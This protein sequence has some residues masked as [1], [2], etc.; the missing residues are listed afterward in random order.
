MDAGYADQAHMS[1]Q[2]RRFS[3]MTI[4]RFLA[5]MRERRDWLQSGDVAFV[6]YEAA[7]G[8]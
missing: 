5:A 2:F 1:R 4:G 7:E 3:G 8:Q 6:Q